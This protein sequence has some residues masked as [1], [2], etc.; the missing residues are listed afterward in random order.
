M[1]IFQ[2]TINPTIA[3]QLKAREK[4]ISQYGVSGKDAKGNNTYAAGVTE[5]GDTFLRFVTGKNAWVRMISGVNANF[6]GKVIKDKNGAIVKDDNT[7]Y[8]KK[9]YSYT[10]DQLARKYIL[11]GGTLY[12]GN[13][14]KFSLRS[15]VNNAGGV[16]GSDIDYI[17]NQKN[18]VSRDYGLRPMPG[19]TS[20]SVVNKSAYGSLREA[21]IEYYVWDKH[22]LEEIEV[23]FMRTGYTVFLEWGWSQYID[24]T[25][26]SGI[27]KYPD[28]VNIK[29]FDTPSL[30]FFKQTD[31][32]V[33][34]KVID[35]TIN[36]TKGNYDAMLG[37]I[38]NFSWQL[39]PNGGFK[40]TT[41]LISRG[42]VLES[43]KASSNPNVLLGSVSPERDEDNSPDK[44]IYSLFEKIFLTLKAVIND[45][46]ITF[47][48]GELA[49]TGSTETEQNSIR[50]AIT[51]TYKDIVTALGETGDTGFKYKIW[52]Q[53]HIGESIGWTFT[54]HGP[55]L[56]KPV[57][58]ELDGTALEYINLN[59]LVA[60][61]NRFFIARK[62]STSDPLV[63]IVLPNDTPCLMSEDTVSIDPT[64]CLIANKYATFITDSEGKTGQDLGFEPL[65]YS[66]WTITSDQTKYTL[67]SSYS[68]PEFSQKVS[69]GKY[70]DGT[71]FNRVSVG[72]IG[73][74]YVSIYKV[75]E[76]YRKLA[77]G[78]NGVD[79]TRFLTDLL[80]EVSIALGGIN[81]FKLF[82]SKNVIQIID[83]KYLET[84]TDKN[85]KGS[86]KVEFDLIG[87]KSIFRDVKMNSRIYAE[88]SSMIGIAAGSQRQK[89]DSFDKRNLGDI[90]ASTQY[91]LNEGLE[92][93]VKNELDISYN[94]G[95]TPENG[96]KPDGVVLYYYNIYNNIVSLAQYIK[97]KV[98]GV[99]DPVLT[100]K[101]TTI[102]QEKEIVNASSLL[103][104]FHY[105]INGKDV[106]FKSLIPFELEVT[107]DGIGGLVVGQI[108]KINKSLLPVTY[109]NKN[110]GFIITGISQNLQ[111]ND[112]TTDVKTQI[113]LLDNDEYAPAINKNDL[114][115]IIA[116]IK[117]QATQNT[118]LPIAMTDYLLFLTK[119]YGTGVGSTYWSE[120]T[121]EYNQWLP[122]TFRPDQ[123]PIRVD[124]NSG[125]KNYI[126]NVWL[127]IAKQLNYPNLPNSAD[128]FGVYKSADFKTTTNFDFAA[129][130]KF[131]YDEAEISSKYIRVPE[132]GKVANDN[133]NR[134]LIEKNSFLGRIFG[135]FNTAVID[136]ES[137][138]TRV[139]TDYVVYSL[140]PNDYDNDPI[141][142]TVIALDQYKLWAKYA[143]AIKKWLTSIDQIQFFNFPETL[144]SANFP[145]GDPSSVSTDVFYIMR[146]KTVPDNAEYEYSTS[147]NNSP[148]PTFT[149]LFPPDINEWLGKTK[150]RMS[151]N[152]FGINFVGEDQQTSGF[153]TLKKGSFKD[154]GLNYKSEL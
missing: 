82:T 33:I 74:I 154:V 107:L 141:I 35:T 80:D 102:P 126:K 75:L 136:L 4:V 42:E 63:Y 9:V 83:A 88:Q 79:I 124:K 151:R 134:P 103:K 45:S 61:L 127:P 106:D 38:K 97:R 133:L 31:E 132:A 146:S 25:Q 94:N 28:T 131:V 49:V 114:K 66:G 87:L 142:R 86:D 108:F 65:M 115:K 99:P 57:K 105:Q 16:Y 15:G 73:M 39:M 1:S 14:D 23:L 64:T 12:E 19:I 135:T 13:P 44:P 11:E 138:Y 96:I 69:T 140:S 60:I 130:D 46:E 144:A 67:A 85:G 139:I 58:G 119:R 18:K 71:D 22:Q 8:P 113:C 47:E 149:I 55:G 104:T 53:D 118:W 121:N 145:L 101:V 68:L 10:G 129:F 91:S 152:N 62:K 93:R 34:Y 54:S 117:A 92:D 98:L 36:D 123:I 76:I 153:Y 56:L 90:Y 37:Y 125:F 109:Y 89:N 84:S 116:K 59:N 27:N 3:A 128:D 137:T 26:P 78:E 77:G 48:T 5:R 51:A 52:Y 7:G 100:Y 143:D 17:S 40:C 110:L 20:V 2:N 150:Y 41:V 32:D 120:T 24:H 21:T 70:E 112:W 6:N 81:D 50:N 95:Q 111:N 148:K 72:Q 30:D 122:C 147:L 29:N 43:I